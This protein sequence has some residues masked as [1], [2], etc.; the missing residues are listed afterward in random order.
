MEQPRHLSLRVGHVHA[1]FQIQFVEGNG[2]HPCLRQI[3]AQI[4]GR[5]KF[6][7]RRQVRQVCWIIYQMEKRDQC[8]SLASAVG[9]IQLAHCLV[10]L[11]RQP[12]DYVPRQVAQIVRRIGEREE[13]LRVFVNRALAFLEDDLIQIGGKHRQR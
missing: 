4:N 11:A 9:E 10:A 8:V 1:R 3:L 12:P 5:A 13:F 7:H 2:C 6:F